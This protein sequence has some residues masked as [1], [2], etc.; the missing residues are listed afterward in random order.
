MVADKH[1]G[2]QRNLAAGDL[3]DVPAVEVQGPGEVLD[4]PAAVAG[5]AAE[6]VDG[7]QVL[8]RPGVDGQVRLGEDQHQ[9]DRLVREDDV[10]FLEHVAAAGVHGRDRDPGQVLEVV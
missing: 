8:L 10:A 6:Q 2:S 7:D 9:G 4:D 3:A 5:A 1:A